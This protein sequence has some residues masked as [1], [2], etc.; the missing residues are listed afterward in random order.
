V[1]E[2]EKM[3]KELVMAYFKALSWHLL[4]RIEENYEK[5]SQYLVCDLSQPQ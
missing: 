5:F 3:W 2:L 1:N 4:G